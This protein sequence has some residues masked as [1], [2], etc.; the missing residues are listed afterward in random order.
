MVH[1]VYLPERYFRHF[2]HTVTKLLRCRRRLGGNNIG[3]D[4]LKE[5]DYMQT[6]GRTDGR[7]Q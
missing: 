4:R 2:V 7:E 1:T 5:I 3:D 6:D